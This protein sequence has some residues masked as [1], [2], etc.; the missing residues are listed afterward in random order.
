[1]EN[2]SMTITIDAVHP[3]DVHDHGVKSPL[4]SDHTPASELPYMPF[5]VTS[6]STSRQPS[7]LGDHAMGSIRLGSTDR[8]VH[9]TKGDTENNEEKRI[10]E[11]IA[12]RHTFRVLSGFLVAFMAGWGDGGRCLPVKNVFDILTIF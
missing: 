11:R 1:M 10:N 6:A 2:K 9:A 5:V 8:I 7:V 4:P 12:R 3:F